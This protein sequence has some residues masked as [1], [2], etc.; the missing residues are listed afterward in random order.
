[1]HSFQL[2]SI[3]CQQTI[4]KI[5]ALR[6]R[7]YIY[8]RQ[9]SSFRAPMLWFID[10]VATCHIQYT[11]LSLRQFF[12]RENEQNTKYSKSAIFV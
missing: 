12:S 2:A 6:A 5:N 10:T 3:T 8:I 9:L 7:V 1:M 11:F 4:L